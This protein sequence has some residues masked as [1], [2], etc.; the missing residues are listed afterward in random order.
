MNFLEL[1]QT[2]LRHLTVVAAKE[3]IFSELDGEAVILNL[4]TG[5]Y[6][7]LDVVGA[8]IWTLLQESKTINEVINTLLAEYEVEP[9][10]CERELLALLQKLADQGLIEVKSEPIA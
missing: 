1:E 2:K 6:H 9:E 3:Q 5:V 8:R 4:K 10:R 7:G